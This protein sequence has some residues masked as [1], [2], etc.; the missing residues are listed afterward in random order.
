M[1]FA[2]AARIATG[3]TETVCLCGC[4]RQAWESDW[5]R[6]YNGYAEPCKAERL[7]ADREEAFQQ[8][9]LDEREAL[10]DE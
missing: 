7:E 4:G 10:S 8:A 5:W 1:R 2:D 9:I 6:P 3:F